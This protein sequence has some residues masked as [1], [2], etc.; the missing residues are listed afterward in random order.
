MTKLVTETFNFSN[1]KPITVGQVCVTID[2]RPGKFMGWG[3][4]REVPRVTEIV[5]YFLCIQNTS[6]YIPGVAPGPGDA[7]L[8]QADRALVQII[9]Q[10]VTV[11]DGK[12]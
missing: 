8:S 10:A 2:G 1:K 7:L 12:V 3:Y 6:L 4:E 5:V 9:Q 11:K